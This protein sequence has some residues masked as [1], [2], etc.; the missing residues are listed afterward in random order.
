MLLGPL[1]LLKVLFHE[2]IIHEIEMIISENTSQE[3]M[4]G[5]LVDEQKSNSFS[6]FLNSLGS[7]FL[8]KYR[9]TTSVGHP[10]SEDF[11]QKP[12]LVNVKQENVARDLAV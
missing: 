1:H 9:P 7:D 3:L 11:A 12:L 10:D 8:T 2:L 6:N 5:M 4:R